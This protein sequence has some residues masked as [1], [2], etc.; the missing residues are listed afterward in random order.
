VA[1]C[2]FSVRTDMPCGLDT[3]I[4]QDIESRFIVV[5]LYWLEGIYHCCTLPFLLF[6][7]FI[8]LFHLLKTGYT[9]IIKDNKQITI[10]AS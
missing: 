3:L 6:L 7:F 2:L 10:R 1:F 5:L 8:S 9:G 4:E